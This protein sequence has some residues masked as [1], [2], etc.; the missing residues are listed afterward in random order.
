MSTLRITALAVAALFAAGGM[1]AVAA[2]AQASELPVMPAAEQCVVPA[3][4]VNETSVNG[5][6]WT[7]DGP[8]AAPIGATVEYRIVVSVHGAD[9]VGF[10]ETPESVEYMT[11]EHG[12]VYTREG[13]VMFGNGNYSVHASVGGTYTC[14]RDSDMFFVEASRFMLI[15]VVPEKPWMEGGVP[16]FPEVEGIHYTATQFTETQWYV[17]AWASD[18]YVIAEGEQVEWILPFES[19]EGGTGGGAGGAGGENGGQNGGGTGGEFEKETEVEIAT[20]PASV[21]NAAAPTALATT[22]GTFPLTTLL[23]GLAMLGAGAFAMLRRRQV[24]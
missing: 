22:G 12:G 1:A 15:E 21:A 3:T 11:F 24:A 9:F 18:G 19:T 20:T 23:A 2:P 5:R 8:I 10:H 17:N 13:S 7:D 16:V 6:P 4:I 14:P